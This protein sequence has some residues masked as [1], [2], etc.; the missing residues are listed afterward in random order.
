MSLPELEKR[1]TT[2]AAE[3]READTRLRAL[4]AAEKPDEGVHY[5]GDI[6][7]LRREKLQK[8]LEME[9]CAA[10]IRFLQTA[11]GSLQ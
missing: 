11:A 4:S 9:Y 10:G 3:I 7:R 5:A 8:R 1:L 6:H 2:L